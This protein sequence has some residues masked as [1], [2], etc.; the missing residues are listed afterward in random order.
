MAGVR[1]CEDLRTANASIKGATSGD[2]R[3]CGSATSRANREM[4]EQIPKL[5][6]GGTAGPFRV[7]EGLQVVALCSKEGASGLPTRDAISQQILLQKLEAGE[8]ALH[9]RPAPRR[10]H[11]HHEAAMTAAA[12]ARRHHGRAGRHRRRTQ[13]QGLAG[14]QRATRPFFAIDDPAR[15]AAL[16]GKLGL[17]V[18]VREIAAARRSRRGL[19]DRAAGAA[20]CGCRRRP[21]PASPTRPTPPA[22]LEA[23][24][25]ATRLAQAGEIAGLVTNPDPEEDPAGCGLPASR[26]HRVPRRAGGRASTSP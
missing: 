10:H 18:P 24:E 6:P 26:P 9:A 2:A 1:T 5:A 16:A 25:R 11:R 13:P 23:I 17:A 21:R 12:A 7:A 14:A 8:P 19:R 3:P 15:L 20:R 22:T 4:Y